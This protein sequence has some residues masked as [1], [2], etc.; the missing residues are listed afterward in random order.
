MPISRR[1]SSKLYDLAWSVAQ[2]DLCEAGQHTSAGYDPNDPATPRA[3]R[4]AGYLALL[5]VYG[6]MHA[7]LQFP[8]SH[9][10]GDQFGTH[11]HQAPA[12]RYAAHREGVLGSSSRTART[13]WWSAHAVFVV[14][15]VLQ[16]VVRVV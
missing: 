11:R 6:R 5:D 2:D 1:L 9:D 12:C 14:S 3:D 10:L 4:Q 7:A 15:M 8:S 16:P 13:A